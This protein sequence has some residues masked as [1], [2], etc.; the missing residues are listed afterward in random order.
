MKR[1][2]S[3]FLIILLLMSSCTARPD[4]TADPI[5]DNSGEVAPDPWEVTVTDSTGREVTT[6]ADNGD[7]VS[8]SVQS[9]SLLIALGA[10]KRLTG[11]EY[12]AA[13]TELFKLAFDGI[14]DVKTVTNENGVD[15]NAIIE[16]KP[17]LVVLNTDQSDIVSDLENAGIICAVVA[18]DTIDNIKNSIELV[19]KMIN[20]EKRAVMIKNY[21]TAALER[22][23]VTT[24]TADELRK[25]S[26]HENDEFILSM[27]KN[28][29]CEITDDTELV[30]AR[31]DKDVPNAVKVPVSVEK[32][33]E[34]S[35]SLVLGLYWYCHSIYPE[36]LSY[37]EVSQHAKN[38][39]IEFYGL[40][41]TPEQLGLPEKDD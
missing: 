33:D 25:V 29:K 26:V 23:Y 32:W 5:I 19:G 2:V 34:P 24:M 38:F 18:L 4:D 17:G 41:L 11:V 16:Q 15:V 31:S 3:V 40:E 14:K 35:I 13:D 37:N 39:Y 28:I 36:L 30:I 6:T 7:I 21:Y 20:A 22:M 8:T 12:T 1:V 27:L 10:E 9:T